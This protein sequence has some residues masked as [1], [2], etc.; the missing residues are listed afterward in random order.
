MTLDSLQL[1]FFKN[2]DEASLRLSP[3]L[4][5]FIGDNGSGKTN[6]LDAVHYLSLTKS[7]ITAS[8]ALCIKQG[9]DFFV[10]KGNFSSEKIVG[11]ETIQVSLRLGQKKTL[12]HNKQPYERMADHIGR[13]PAVLISPYD[14]DL[15][16][17]GS[18]DRRRYFDSLMAQLDHE[19]LELLMAYNALLRQRNAVLKRG[20]QPTHGFDRDYLLALDEQLAPIGQQ[21]T[22]LREAFLGEYVPIFQRHYQQLADG[23]ELVTLT[24]KSQLLGADFARLLRN[25]ERRDFALQR[26]TTGSHRDDFVFLMNELPVKSHA[27]QGQQK[28][29]AIALKLAQFEILATKQQHKPLLL[30]DDIFDRLDDK[31]IA[32][33][34]ELVADETFGQVF[35]TDTNLE[36]TDQ[37]LARVAAPILRFRVQDGTVTPV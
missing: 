10:V 7:A 19:F 26:S 30:L 5:C 15:I 25:N 36:R 18:E 27:S 13:Y 20:D 4:N 2:Y 8:D 35:L 23:R 33:L 32:R 12:T 31:R 21:L 6:L 11:H 17:Q 28:S 24:Y 1:L 34:L 37:A 3:G 16:R 29:F 14:T 22:I 9:A